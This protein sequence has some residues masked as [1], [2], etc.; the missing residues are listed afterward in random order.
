MGF[1]SSKS[2]PPGATPQ[3]QIAQLYRDLLGRAADVQGLQHWTQKL[4]DGVKIKSIRAEIMQSAEYLSRGGADGSPAAGPPAS[5]IALHHARVEMVRQLPKAQ[6]ILDLG[7]GA[8]GDPR[9]AL[10]V[11][12]YP[13]DFDS[14]HIIEPP[15]DARH[16]IYQNIPD[17]TKIISTDRGPVHYHYGSMADLS[18]FADES[19]DMV[20]SGETIEHVTVDECRQTLAEVRRVLKPTGSFCFDTP[21]RAVTEIQFPNGFINPEHKIEYR[22]AQMLDL[23]SEAQ[24]RPIEMKGITYMPE[25]VRQKRFMEEEMINNCGLYADLELCYLLYYRCVR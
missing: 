13:Y 23:L 11:M 6:R 16:A 10:V 9:G 14:L 3:E 7:G 17:I 18:R 20:M 25:T 5:L 1:F 15:P 19:F 8:I 12:G 22:H 21:N 2:S 4:E 24:L